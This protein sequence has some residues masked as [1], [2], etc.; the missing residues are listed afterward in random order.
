MIDKNMIKISWTDDKVC[1]T[2]TKKVFPSKEISN[3]PLESQN[4]NQTFVFLQMKIY[5]L[6]NF[7][8]SKI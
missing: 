3:V 5:Q 7:L 8:Y 2:G 6:S 4:F 1:G